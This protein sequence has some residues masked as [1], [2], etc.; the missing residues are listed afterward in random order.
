VN[1]ARAAGGAMAKGA[2]KGIR[3]AGQGAG[4][5]RKGAQA[6]GT[7]TG[8][9]AQ[10]AGTTAG[11]S[12]QATGRAGRRATSDARKLTDAARNR[13]SGNQSGGGWGSR[14]N[15]FDRFGG[16]NAEDQQ[17]DPA[18]AFARDASAKFTQAA[19]AAFRPG[20]ALRRLGRRLLPHQWL[21]LR[22]KKEKKH[23]L[24]PWVLIGAPLVFIMGVTV[25]SGE[26]IG[27]TQGQ[28]LALASAGCQ[29]LMDTPDVAERVDIPAEVLG[30]YCAAAGAY[31]VDWAIIAA[32]G[33]LA[34]SHGLP[35]GH[36]TPGCEPGTMDAQG[37]RGPMRIRGSVWRAH[38]D[39]REPDLIGEPVPRDEERDG[40]YATDADG[41]GLADPWSAIDATQGVARFLRD[42]G[43]KDDPRSAL[44]A[45]NPRAGFADE[46]L[47]LAST[48]RSSALGQGGGWETLVALGIPEHAARAYVQALALIQGIEPG[49]GI[50]LAYLAGFGKMESG[51]GTVAV[52]VETGKSD[53]PA[54]RESVRWDANT[55]NST[56]KIL[57]AALDGSGVGGNT[58]PHHNNLS[59]ADRAFYRQ[60]DPYI[61]AVGPTQFLPGTW[62]GV[63]RVADGN[64]DGVADPFNYYDGALA[65]AVKT[66]RDGDGLH[67]ESDQRR[68]ALAYN[69]VGWYADG[70]MSAA[71]E[72]R[73]RLAEL[74]PSDPQGSKARYVDPH[75]TATMQRLLD[76]LIRLF[77]RGQGVG[78]YRPG[79]PQDH[80]RGR[81][82]DFMMSTAGQ[83]PSPEMRTHGQAMADWLVANAASRGVQYVIWEQRIWNIDRA[84]EGWRRMEDRGS[85]TQNHFDH[86]HVS[87][88]R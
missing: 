56:P 3:A 61:R 69:H 31:E 8:K 6:V 45:F 12:A 40:G 28:L 11:R 58:R 39:D 53:G 52:N 47:A 68:A 62:E 26:A 32:I 15:V 2:G 59:E 49:C 85:I 25:L 17:A 67:T 19:R 70:V 60:D 18:A 87:V 46:V 42:K 30:V 38:V 64:G 9:G 21:K 7:A 43:V 50:D 23:R 51:H 48:L 79:D 35:A 66:C 41:N 5:T 10:A 77:G 4:A 55:G 73:E 14:G 78:C 74:A 84:R 37:G 83:H 44:T 27:G 13:R 36:E 1:G 86:V 71:A 33:Q 22:K 24:R 34:C 81:A 80:G 20:R 57:G 72:Y 29:D 75:N 76:E 88:Q 54:P 65:T 63:R 16:P 82:C